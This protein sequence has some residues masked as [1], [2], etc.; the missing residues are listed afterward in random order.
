MAL[1]VSKIS[2][3]LFFL[4]SNNAN[5]KS[6]INQPAKY[7]FSDDGVNLTICIGGDTYNLAWST[8]TV[9]TS[10]PTTLSSAKVLVNAILGT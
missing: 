7:Q 4:D 1:T 8:L 9:G 2:G 10:T 3:V 6:Y 5:P